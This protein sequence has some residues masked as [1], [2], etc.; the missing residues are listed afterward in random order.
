ML[1]TEPQPSTLLGLHSPAQRALE[2]MG[3]PGMD[4]ANLTGQLGVTPKTTID[5]Q[6]TLKLHHFTPM[7][8]EVYRVPVLIVTSLVNQPYILDLVPGQSMVEFL[9]KKGFDVYMIEWGRPRKEHRNLSL[10]DH[11]L[12]R[13]P[14]CVNIVLSHSGESQLSIIGYCVGGLLA[15]LWAAIDAAMQ[16]GAGAGPLK[17]LVCMATPVNSD[18]LESLK[19]WMGPDFDEEALLAAHGNVPAEWVQNAL[20]ALRPFGKVAGAANLLNQ[21]DQEAIVRSNLR[22][23]KWETDNIPFPGGVFRQMVNDFLRDNCL[24]N[25][26][27]KIGAY[28]ADLAAIRVPLLH[29]LAQDDHITPYASSRDLVQ[30]VSSSDREEVMIKGGHV[31]LVAG[32]GAQM[33][34]WPALEAWLAQRS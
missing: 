26:R 16:G 6:G 27:W 24:I 11:V 19:T 10:E 18:G 2:K 22:M 32:R 28:S 20:R 8:D 25:G 3:I 15:V 17:N 14:A 21:A 30:R 34:M 23:G 7:C 31:G 9:L 33:R 29:L 12:D 13:L 4:F 5:A 1:N